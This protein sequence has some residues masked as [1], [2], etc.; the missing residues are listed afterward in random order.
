MTMRQR[1]VL[2]VGVLVMAASHAEILQG[3]E[4]LDTLGDIR[5]KFPNAQLQPIKAAWVK[6]DQAFYSLEGVGLPGK[7]RL[8]FDDSRPS[9]RTSYASLEKNIAE[10]TEPTQLDKKCSTISAINPIKVTTPA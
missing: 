3:I 5:K 8:A 1:L 7:I 4:P 10:K 6:E 9:W 2:L